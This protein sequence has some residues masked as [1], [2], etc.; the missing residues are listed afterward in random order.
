MKKIVQGIGLWVGWSQFAISA[1]LAPCSTLLDKSLCAEIGQM[2]IVGFG[3]LNQDETGKIL[4]QDSTNTHFTANSIIAHHIV[5]QHIG[6]VILFSQS[7]RNTKTGEF[8]R[9]R[10]VQN[11]EQ[12]AELNNA[13]Q[14][15]NTTVRQEQHLLPLPLFIGIDQEG[16][17][18]DRLPATQ[19]FPLRTLIPQA[20]GAEEKI[21]GDEP[22][23]KQ[24]A[25][26]KTYEYA[27]QL[28]LELKN[29][30]FNLNFA[31]VMDVNVNP[32]NPIIGGLG[33]S[34]S[35]DPAIVVD[36]AQQ[37]I[38]AFQEENIIPVL[39][40]FPGHGSSQADTHLNLVDVTKTYQKDQELYP[41]AT[42][43]AAHYSGMV[44]TTHVINGQIDQHACKKGLKE[45]P[46]TW[47]PGTLSYATLTELLRHQL[48][49]E[50]VIVSDDMTM[51]AI[52]LEYP[53]ISAIE[54]S[55]N[56]GVDLF[57]MA[58][59]DHD[60]TDDFIDT[61]AYLVKVGKIKPERIHEAYRRIVQLK[62]HALNNEFTRR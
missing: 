42:L 31:P 51:G 11:P 25:L 33:R 38:R 58:N 24:T 15:F 61:L 41:Y 27:H 19:G 34:F 16:G 36:Q 10:N 2:V 54:K 32:L 30:H 47:C 62:H 59:N 45:D 39:K 49:F 35:S 4:W 46:A 50:G 6:G 55:V 18:A 52:T 44:M 1:S 5:E 22:A 43:F 3:G 57:I 56:A 28:A 21:A 12:V 26:K 17:H 13:L 9:D 53:L 7:Y 29:A 48:K 60:Y 20:F 8:I 40:H 37:F 14:Q 23:L